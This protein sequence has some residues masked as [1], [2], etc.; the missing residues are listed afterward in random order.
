MEQFISKKQKLE[1]NINTLKNEQKLDEE[2][3]SKEFYAEFLTYLKEKAN[4]TKKIDFE[5]TLF[6]KKSKDELVTFSDFILSISSWEFAKKTEFY[7]RYNCNLQCH[8]QVTLMKFNF[9]ADSSVTTAADDNND[10]SS[11]SWAIVEYNTHVNA[12]ALS[13]NYS[14][15]IE[16]QGAYNKK[17]ISENI[18][19]LWERYIC[20]FCL[21]FLI[22]KGYITKD[23]DIQNERS[24]IRKYLFDSVLLYNM[25]SRGMVHIPFHEMDNSKM[26][27]LWW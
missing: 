16:E 21:Q 9:N 26:P 22:Y 10:S 18:K 11:S 20:Q 25:S 13:F 17:K 14:K 2:N 6:T 3:A 1:D 19:C 23:N 4:S 12:K 7:S 5:H 15:N 8:E 24:Y 27:Y